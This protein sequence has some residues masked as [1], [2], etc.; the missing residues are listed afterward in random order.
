MHGRDAMNMKRAL[1]GTIAAMS[2]MGLPAGAALA[3][4]GDGCGGG[5]HHAT[6]HMKHGGGGHMLRDLDLTEEQREQIK[7]IKQSKKSAM[8]EHRQTLRESREALRDAARGDD[9]DAAKVRELADAHAAT[10]A[11]L[12]VA[13]AEAFH[14]VRNVL[15]PE[16]RQA[17]AERKAKHD[18]GHKGHEGG[19][20]EQT[21]AES[22]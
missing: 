7:E 17:L 12:M 20:N 11:E 15:T 1:V 18:K 3:G 9:F 10:M 14:E 5:K 21:P 16:Q 8:R 19:H 6:S 22:N 2:L 4:S 13:R